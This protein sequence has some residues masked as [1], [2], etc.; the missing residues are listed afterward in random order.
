MRAVIN[1]KHITEEQVARL[2]LEELAP[3]KFDPDIQFLIHKEHADT[4]R[5]TRFRPLTAEETA[6]LIAK[7]KVTVSSEESIAPALYD[8]LP[9]E[10]GER[11]VREH[12]EYK[13]RENKS[14]KEEDEWVSQKTTELETKTRNKTKPSRSTKG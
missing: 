6:I 12:F 10:E 5:E 14:K 7:G 9:R 4:P 1:E 13:N 2:E 8:T 3:E 11:L